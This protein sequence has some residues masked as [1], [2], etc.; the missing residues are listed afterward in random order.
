MHDAHHAEYLAAIAAMPEHTISP[1]RCLDGHGIGDTIAFRLKGWSQS[2]YD[3]GRI[4]DINESRNVLL[5]ETAGDI[6]EV[7]P[8]P[9]P[10]GNVLPF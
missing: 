4:V 2:S 5:V 3:D 7:D 9:W 1:R 8:R 6:V 10:V